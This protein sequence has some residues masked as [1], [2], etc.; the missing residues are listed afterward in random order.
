VSL[1]KAEKIGT[2][3]LYEGYMLYP[4][5]PSAI[6]NRQRCGF[7][8]LFPESCQEVVRCAEACRNITQC[9]V[10]TTAPPVLITILV[11]F[12]HMR[13]RT[14][15]ARMPDGEPRFRPVES[16]VV[17]GRLLQSWDEAVERAVHTEVE[18]AGLL[19]EPCIVPFEFPESA[20]TVELRDGG[21]EVVGLI[22]R[23]Q[24]PV[25]GEVRVGAERLRDSL[26]RLTVE[27][28]NT[29]PAA[30]GDRDVALSC[31]LASAHTILAVRGGEF[32]S[33]LDPP[34]PLR[35]A[36][37]GCSNAGLYPVLVGDPGDRNVVLSSPIILYDYPQI[38]P[39]SA[40]DFFDSTEIDELLT[41][42]VMTLTDKEKNEI[43]SADDRTR[44]LLER[45]E[46]NV[47]EQLMRT[48][49]LMRNLRPMKDTTP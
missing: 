44:R 15:H 8:T 13:K 20:D 1:E 36:A 40:G 3:I 32:I 7:G 41:L 35:E 5:R 46:T 4:Y 9:L 23:A 34:E 31:S 11:R 28:V 37:A 22:T 43:R 48:H 27:F 30:S 38:A 6:K 26:H 47:R 12:L 2:A 19:L 18:L 10:T 39:E 49:G 24:C 29:T 33:L 42:R 14:V 17:D 25:S 45:T 16:L 21:G